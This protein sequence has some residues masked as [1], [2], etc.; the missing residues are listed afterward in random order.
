MSADEMTRRAMLRFLSIAGA[1][2]A[3][4]SPVGRILNSTLTGIADKAYADLS[5]VQPRIF[6]HINAEGG[7]PRWMWDLILAPTD[8]DLNNR[9]HRNPGIG[10]AFD[11]SGD[12]FL[13]LKYQTIK[14]QGINVPLLWGSNVPTSNGGVRPMSDLLNN[15]LIIRGCNLKED[16]HPN[17]NA[18]QIAPIAGQASITGL[19]ADNALEPIPALQISGTSAGNRFQSNSGAAQAS[20]LYPSAYSITD[21]M[22]PFKGVLPTSF[23]SNASV[24]AAVEKA[25]SAFQKRA[26]SLDQRSAILFSDRQKTESL[27]K[28]NLNDYA[29]YFTASAD[30]YQDLIGRAFMTTNIPGLTDKPVRGSTTNVLFSHGESTTIADDNLLEIFKAATIPGLAYEFATAEFCI[31]QKLTRS[32]VLGAGGTANLNILKLATGGSVTAAP[33][34]SIGHDQHYE[35]GALVAIA[36][37]L[38]F[39]ALSACLLEF[40]DFLKARGLFSETVI[41]FVGDFNRIPAND[42]TGSGHG[43]Q[44]SSNLI[45]SGIVPKL[46]VLGNIMSGA[47]AP[48]DESYGTGTWGTAGPVDAL[49]GRQITIGNVTS[50]LSAMLRVELLAKNDQSLVVVEGDSVVKPIIE[51]AKNVE[52]S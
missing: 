18:K 31:M 8:S 39:S 17:N 45:I 29:D 6:V 49:G 11:L 5:G 22:A 44:A 32:F 1:Y 3:M 26:M 52:G 9:F 43:F 12:Q 48:V 21:L 30:R 28:R 20:I 24:N 19:I 46:T 10:N 34:S 16:G 4:M 51:P 23:R 50:T 15:S 13:A 37:S 25:M 36:G 41:N 35:G 47:A 14:Y 33:Q 7:P 40:T 2:G 42:G 27:M 38:Y